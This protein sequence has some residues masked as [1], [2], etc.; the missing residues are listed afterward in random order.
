MRHR[1]PRK[2]SLGWGIGNPNAIGRIETD[3]IVLDIGC[4]SG[5]DLLL[6][7]RRIGPSGRAISI[8][9]TAAMREQAMSPFAVSPTRQGDLF[10]RSNSEAIHRSVE[11]LETADATAKK[12]AL[13]RRIQRWE[14]CLSAS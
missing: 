9:T 8:D 11:F 6:A 5:T 14:D 4:G 2:A 13:T 10:A 7:A 1:S 12:D 3:A